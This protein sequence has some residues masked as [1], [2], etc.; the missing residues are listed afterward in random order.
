[1]TLKF[2]SS[3][4]EPLGIV[5]Y[6]AQPRRVVS[7]FV[8][9]AVLVVAVGF[10]WHSTGLGQVASFK[11]GVVK[12]MV[13]SPARKTGAGFVIAR[14]SN[15]IYIVTAAH[16]VERADK[17]SV[18]FFSPESTP[19]SARTRHVEAGNPQGMALLEVSGPVPPDV[20]A[21]PLANESTFS[22]GESVT[23][24]GH[25]ASTGDWGV[26]T[27]TVSSR[28]GREIVIQAPIEEQASG[29]P[30]FHDNRVLGL[31]VSTRGN[32]GY[33]ITARA[34]QDYVEGFGVVAGRST[35]TAE[36]SAAKPPVETRRIVINGPKPLYVPF[37]S[38]D[39]FQE[40][41]ECPEMVVIP[42]GSYNMGSPPGEG[43]SN[44]RPQ[45]MVTI[46][47]S[48]AVGR[49][50]VT[51]DEWDACVSA[52][53]CQRDQGRGRHPVNN[54]SW[55]NAQEYITWLSK[56]T[57]GH[58]RLLSEA[59]WEYAARAGTTT[60]YHWGDEP[61]GNRANFVGSGSKWSNKEPAPVGSFELNRFGLYDMIGNVSEWVQDCWKNSYAGVPTDGSAW[62]DGSCSRRVVRGGSWNGSPEDARAA[63]RGAGGL[64]PVNVR[65]GK[66]GFRVSR[67]L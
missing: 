20:Q 16:V 19:V 12:I 15:V 7:V 41:A 8:K 34:V 42:E 31:V 10:L 25:Q 66:L 59:E 1:M 24:I 64:L 52:G 14:T 3:W 49:Y 11:S 13:S 5:V 44:E 18:Q 17:I 40:C 48:F 65:Y 27:G 46:A 54:V 51:L 39:V 47:R 21:L 67:T 62:D 38:G 9:Y 56:K 33:A 6:R 32:F 23:A 36:K 35:V 61:G 2:F 63:N 29:G 4:A 55:R 58:Y 28:K 22:G 26:I 53:G 50:E 57:G 43:N 60:R 37:K 45:H 30:V